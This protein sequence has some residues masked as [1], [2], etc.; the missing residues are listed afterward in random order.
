[1]RSLRV[2]YSLFVG[3]LNCR[4]GKEKG[5]VENDIVKKHIRVLTKLFVMIRCL[6][7]LSLLQ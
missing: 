2:T 6:R 1:M 7:L 3:Q 4:T 5:Q